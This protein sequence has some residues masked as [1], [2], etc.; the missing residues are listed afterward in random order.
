LV[1]NSSV[2][3][4]MHGPTNIKFADLTEVLVA[5][6]YFANDP[7]KGWKLFKDFSDFESW[8]VDCTVVPWCAGQWVCKLGQNYIFCG[9]C[10]VFFFLEKQEIRVCCSSVCNSM[11]GRPSWEADSTL[12]T[13]GPEGR[14]PYYL[15]TPWC[16]VLLEKLTALPLVQNLPAF[17]GPR[18][19]ITALT[20]VRQLS[21]SWADYRIQHVKI[22]VLRNA[23]Q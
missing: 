11:K 15:L 10:L 17:H 8:V 19:F 6:H 21:L 20:S 14:L 13:Q 7:K 16:R 4:M 9:L 23:Y 12:A 18:R 3:T 2:F 5:F 1:L 22:I